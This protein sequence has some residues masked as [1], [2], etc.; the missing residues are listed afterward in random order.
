MHIMMKIP[1]FCGRI[2]NIAKTHCEGRRF[3]SGD[4]NAVRER[5]FVYRGLKVTMNERV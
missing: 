2:E 4:S 1:A 3:H 5:I